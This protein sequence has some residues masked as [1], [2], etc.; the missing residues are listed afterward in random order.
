MCGV[1]LGV[2]LVIA[3]GGLERAPLHPKRAAATERV[4]LAAVYETSGLTI[5]ERKALALSLI[6]VASRLSLSSP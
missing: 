1:S 6:I 2:A 4:S 5:R 3:P